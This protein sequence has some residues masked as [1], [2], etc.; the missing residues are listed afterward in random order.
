MIKGLKLTLLASVAAMASVQAQAADNINVVLAGLNE[1]SA[2]ERINFSGKLR[3]LSQ[4]ISASACNLNA[5]I[6]GDLSLQMLRSSHAEFN[7][8][9]DALEFGNIDLHIKNAENRPEVLTAIA[10]LDRKSTRLNSSH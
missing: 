3:M 2:T 6:D 1:S 5:D 10:N 8:I 9:I 7:K 4:R